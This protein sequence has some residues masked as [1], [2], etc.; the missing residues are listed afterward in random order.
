[1]SSNLDSYNKGG[2]LAFMFSIIFCF[3]FFAYV[4][5]IHPGIDL[6]E[7]KEDGAT[8]EIQL[9]EGATPPTD[10]SQIEKP[11]AD[12]PDMIAHGTKIYDTNCAV[13]HGPG[14]NGKGPAGAGLVPPPR[15]LIEGK[16]TQGGNSIGLYKT[17]SNGIPG[18]S[19]AAFKH[20]KPVDRWAV[21]Q[22]I[23][24][25]TNNKVADDAAALESFA[26]SAE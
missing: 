20:L 26:A 14:G 22:Y 17:V 1:M 13:C 5:F 3:A 21:V 7:V 19:M 15:N 2:F 11:W 24:S 23:R 8:G 4:S 9:A 12:N 18:T 10:V 16:W 6:M 25:I